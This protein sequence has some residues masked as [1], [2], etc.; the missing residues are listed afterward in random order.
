MQTDSKISSFSPGVEHSGER[1]ESYAPT[2]TMRELTTLTSSPSTF[3]QQMSVL[4]VIQFHYEVVHSYSPY[5][6]SSPSRPG[7]LPH[8][9]NDIQ[10]SPPSPR[11]RTGFRCART[12]IWKTGK[13]QETMKLRTT[14]AHADWALP[15]KMG[16]IGGVKKWYQS[17]MDMG[18]GKPRTSLREVSDESLLETQHH[19]MPREL[20]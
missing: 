4:N 10:F 18:T 11:S 3:P 9:R 13:G 5:L 20:E 19:E 8:T 2:Q 15:E 17:C 16:G 12:M 6:P 7:R 14:M 1:H